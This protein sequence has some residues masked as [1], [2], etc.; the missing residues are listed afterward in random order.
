MADANAH[1]IPAS[2]WA[3]KGPR[4]GCTINGPNEQFVF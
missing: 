2:F 3:E 1:K 4:P